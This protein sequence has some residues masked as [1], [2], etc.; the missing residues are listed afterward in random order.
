[1]QKLMD[2]ALDD[3]AEGDE[4]EELLA[5]TNDPAKFVA[6]AFPNM[7][8]E[9]WQS[10]V[11]K[12]VGNQLTE[13]ERL[14][15]FKP[16][17]IAISSGNGTGKSILMSWLL[18]WTLTTYE[19]SLAVCTAGSEAQLRIRLW[20]SLAFCFNQLPDDLRTQFEMTA[21]ALYSK[22]NERT[23]GVSMPALG[24]LLIRKVFR[25]STT[26]ESACSWSSTRLQRSAKI[27]SGPQTEC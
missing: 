26:T 6:L 5:C 8:P 3:E 21:T 11:L 18:L 15:R 19:E 24:P 22:Q 4:L 14:G 10:E 12:E 17:Q 2:D 23:C 16:I 27:F 7:K 25:A 9:R 13:N 1:V 20:G